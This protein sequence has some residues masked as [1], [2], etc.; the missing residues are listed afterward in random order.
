MA[1]IA[2][3]A[4]VGMMLA[5][6]VGEM[7]RDLALWITVVTGIVLFLFGVGKFEAVADMLG[8]LTDYVGIHETYIVIVLKMMGIA[9]LSDFTASV[10]RDAGQGTI[11]GQV[12]FFGKISMIL[13]SLPV[14]RSLLASL[15]KLIP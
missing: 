7:R 3:I 12:D 4:L 9:Y 6:I 15:E 2:L 5:V 10:C 13:V 14:L 1:K 11:A 8:E